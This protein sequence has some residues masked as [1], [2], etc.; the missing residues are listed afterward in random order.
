MRYEF[1]RRY[2]CSNEVASYEAASYFFDSPCTGQGFFYPDRILSCLEGR[3]VVFMGDSLSVQQADSLVGMLGW[4]PYWIESTNPYNGG[5]GDADGKPFKRTVKD[6][7]RQDTEEELEWMATCWDLYQSDFP[8]APLSAAAS[9]GN[10][11]GLQS[12][13]ETT[14]S[15]GEEATHLPQVSRTGSNGTSVHMRDFHLPTGN[16][17]FSRAAKDFNETRASDVFV[18]NF[19]AHYEETPEG[20][21]TFKATVF[22]VLAEMAE[23][24]KTATVVWREISPVHFP[25]RNASY[26]NFDVLGSEQKRGA[27]CTGMPP[28][29][30]ARNKW[31]QDYL[32]EKGLTDTVKLLKIYDMSLPRAA[33]HHTCH[34][35]PPSSKDFRT[36]DARRAT[37]SQV[38]NTHPTMPDCRHWSSPG[39]VEEWNALLLH[40][41]CPAG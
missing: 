22:P 39:V 28:R 36:A 21:E 30:F 5:K 14:T 17:W 35:A 41:L 29:V 32:E 38:C 27:C 26:E 16:N 3:R 37:P 19:G 10:Q 23:I 8:P 13:F 40:H 31:V 20:D 7:W 24:G 11:E 25:S 1:P 4:H 33:A 15:H 2:T 34:M 6:C 18:V 12:G 9:D